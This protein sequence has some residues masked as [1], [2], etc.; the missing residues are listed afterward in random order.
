MNKINKLLLFALLV[1]FAVNLFGQQTILS[2]DYNS[3]SILSYNLG[4]NHHFVQIPVGEGNAIAIPEC[5]RFYAPN[6]SYFGFYVNENGQFTIDIDFRD[7][8]IAGISIYKTD[9]ANYEE[10]YCN[11]FDN[12]EINF[13]FKDPSLANQFVTVQLWI[14]DPEYFGTA[15]ISILENTSNLKVPEIDIDLYTPQQ[16]VQEVLISGCVE[17]LNV[18]YTGDNESIG[19]FDNGMPGLSFENGI[20]M[21]TGRVVEAA[22]P[23]NSGSVGTNLHNP[24]DPDLSDIVGGQTHDA[25]VLEFDFIPASASFR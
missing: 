4:E 10:I 20:V 14:S 8:I 2:K 24:G 22:G 1:C 5:S 6:N 23:N 13:S 12:N 16:L 9:N 25:A 19:Y 18:H 15:Q 7:S 21:S 17:A 3:P 11:E